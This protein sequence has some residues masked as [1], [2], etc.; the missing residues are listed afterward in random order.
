[1]SIDLNTEQ[2]MMLPPAYGSNVGIIWDVDGA[3][4]AVSE[5]CGVNAM[6]DSGNGWWVCGSSMCRAPM[7]R[8][9]SYRWTLKYSLVEHESD[10]YLAQWLGFWSG[11]DAADIGVEV[12]R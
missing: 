7:R 8:D 9:L 1:M 11:Y 2:K 6:Y 10:E 3:L 5:C 12:L 4:Y